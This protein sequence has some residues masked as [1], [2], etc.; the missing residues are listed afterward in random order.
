M[1]QLQFPNCIGSFSV[2]AGTLWEN[3]Q[4]CSDL[5]YLQNLFLEYSQPAENHTLCMHTLSTE[6]DGSSGL[7]LCVTKVSQF[8]DPL[9]RYVITQGPRRDYRAQARRKKPGIV[10]VSMKR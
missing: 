5:V 6:A 7:G 1:K 10:V 2:S 3:V 4:I 8:V 9:I